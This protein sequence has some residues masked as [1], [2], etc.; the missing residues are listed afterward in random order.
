QRMRETVM[1]QPGLA[2]RQAM[3]ERLVV[4]GGV[5]KGVLTQYGEEIKAKAVVITTGTFLNGLMHTGETKVE[6]G[7]T[8]ELSAK[9]LP[10]HLRELGFEVGRLK[11]GTNPRVRRDSID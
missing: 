8:G 9:G 3:V 1:R 2:V 6:G 5:V 10:A 11:T 7:R 4:E